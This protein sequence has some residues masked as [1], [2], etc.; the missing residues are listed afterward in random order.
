M[1]VNVQK[2]RR[3]RVRR[4]TRELPAEREMSPG[5]RLYMLLTVIAA[6]GVFVGAYSYSGG[7]VN[8]GG[9]FVSAFVTSLCSVGIY[10]LLFFFG[11]LSAVGQP[12]GYILCFFKGLGTG[13]LAAYAACAMKSGDV[14]AAL[15]ILPFEAVSMVTVIFGARENIRMSSYISGRSFGA[16]GEASDE[17]SLRLYL[18][19]FALILLTGIAAAAMRGL[20]AAVL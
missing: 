20:M 14:C 10:V 16:L 2:R 19:K 13:Y 4:M 15:N 11:G 9:G 8:A 7:E 6:A 18:A 3:Y 12:M 5:R 17:G 1:T